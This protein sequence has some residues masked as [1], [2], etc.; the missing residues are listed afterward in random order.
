[1]RQASNRLSKEIVNQRI[2]HRGI[3]LIGE[4]I[5]NSVKTLFKCANNHTWLAKPNNVMSPRQSGCPHCAGQF[6]LTK[7][8]V[9]SR[10]KHK[11]LELV[12]DYTG[13]DKPSLFQCLQCD[14]EFIASP[15]N[16]IVKS[17]C[18]DCRTGGGF[19][20]H[21]PA[22][23]YVLLFPKLNFIKYGITNNLQQRIGKHSRISECI[24]MRTIEFHSGKDALLFEQ[25]VKK[26]FG[27]NFVSKEILKDGYTETLPIELLEDLIQI[28]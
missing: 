8:I 11:N 16:I 15:Y 9:N 20:S 13:I 24:V 5:R 21:Q 3:E 1:M 17:H 2:A 25:K 10:I 6:P 19:K 4:Y 14:R 18:P 27:G 12:G 26:E 28:N 22:T 23:F 7:D